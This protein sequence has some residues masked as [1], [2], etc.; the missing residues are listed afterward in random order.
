MSQLL[1]DVSNLRH[2]V[3]VIKSTGIEVLIV[4]TEPIILARLPLW[5]EHN[6]GYVRGG[7][8]RGPAAHQPLG[9]IFIRDLASPLAL[10]GGIA[11]GLVGTWSEG[12]TKCDT[13]R[14]VGYHTNILLSGRKLGLKG[15][16]LLA[17]VR[18]L[19]MRQV[20]KIHTGKKGVPALNGLR[21]HVRRVQVT[22]FEPSNHVIQGDGLGGHVSGKG[23]NGVPRGHPE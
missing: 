21:G 19:L 8:N 2:G 22:G 23:V 16:Q 17:M 12:I 5:Y 20:P 11:R 7:V 6:V 15:E 10:L 1:Q 9:N 14:M 4:H 13:K 3:L 18:E